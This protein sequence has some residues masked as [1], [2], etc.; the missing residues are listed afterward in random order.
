MR[1]INPPSVRAALGWIRRDHRKLVTVDGR[2]AF[3]SGLCIGEMWEGYPDKGLEPWRDTGV[4][5][6]GP[7][8][9]HAERAF[10]E[11]WRMTGGTIERG[12]LAG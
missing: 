12:R 2:I 5:I 1:V 11:T 10:A 9:A 6:T 4:A 3:I 7:A 8:V